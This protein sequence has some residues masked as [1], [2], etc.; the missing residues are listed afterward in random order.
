MHALAIVRQLRRH[1][2]RRAQGLATL[3]VM[4][5]DAACPALAAL[6]PRVWIDQQG[7][8]TDLLAARVVDALAG[9]APLAEAALQC[10][11]RAEGIPPSGRASLD[12]RSASEQAR[13][14]EGVALRHTAPNVRSAARWLMGH[15]A[16]AEPPGTA[17][18]ALALL[19]RFLPEDTLP[20]VVL[21][22]ALATELEPYARL[23]FS[24]PRL[25]LVV[26]VE[27]PL[28]VD[29]LRDLSDR[30]RSLVRAGLIAGAARRLPAAPPSTTEQGGLMP[31]NPLVTVARDAVAAARRA[32]SLG[33]AD[34]NAQCD[35]ARSLAEAY[36]YEL[37]EAEPET[38]GVFA[39]NQR[40][41]VTFG[42]APAEIDL[43]GSALAIAIEVD[44]Y[45]HFT[46][47]DAYRRDR[48]KDLLMQREGLLVVRFLAEDVVSDGHAIVRLVREL[49]GDRRRHNTVRMKP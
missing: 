35:R 32:A 6:G 27:Q 8:S 28:A 7:G 34:A 9:V 40:L 13:W 38:R 21:R 22:C 45:F 18:D 33:S 46:G 47:G 31:L 15:L 16:L 26:V 29:A 1:A 37:L 5:G 3:S 17:F 43:L 49:V 41:E 12:A 36:L 20:A 30:A 19:L 42:R 4:E 10:V 24:L 11:E 25:P 14:L 2:A 23:A 39:L 44:G 48:R